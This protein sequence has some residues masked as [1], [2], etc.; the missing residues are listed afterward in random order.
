MLWKA[1]TFS[2]SALEQTKQSKKFVP[3]SNSMQ[4]Q[5]DPKTDFLCKYVYHHL[6]MDCFHPTQTVS[7]KD[8]DEIKKKRKDV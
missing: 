5:Q 6:H 2:F 7:M 1:K 3:S 4:K 8:I